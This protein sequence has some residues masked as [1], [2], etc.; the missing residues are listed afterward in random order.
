MERIV[1]NWKGDTVVKK[2]WV[3][4]IELYIKKKKKKI[5]NKGKEDAE[6]GIMEQFTNAQTDMNHVIQNYELLYEVKY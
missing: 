4:D 3:L 1:G 5:H 2:G 6:E